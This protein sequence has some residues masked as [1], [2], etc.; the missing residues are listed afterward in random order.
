M[1]RRLS[2][3]QTQNKNVFFFLLK[4]K[5]VEIVQKNW[6]DTVVKRI[7][8]SLT[9]S[10]RADKKNLKSI[11][12]W[13]QSAMYNLRN[14][15]LRCVFVCRNKVNFI[16]HFVCFFAAAAAAAAAASVVHNNKHNFNLQIKKKKNRFAY[17]TA[18]SPKNFYARQKFYI[19]NV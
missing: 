7:Y 18:S 17:V 16:F 6:S 12:A 10:C 1:L 5:R 9:Y 14:L 19:L 15:R 3:L 8:N 4:E 13:R 11:K 2:K